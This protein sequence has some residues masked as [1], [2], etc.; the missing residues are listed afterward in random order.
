MKHLVICTS[1]VGLLTLLPGRLNAELNRLS[2]D[3]RFAYRLKEDA[4]LNLD[5][6]VESCRIEFLSRCRTLM[7]EPI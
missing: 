1:F 4:S 3:A 7:S 5:Y 6:L 2:D